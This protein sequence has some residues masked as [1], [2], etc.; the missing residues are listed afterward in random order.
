[1]LKHISYP[2]VKLIFP[3][4]AALILSSAATAQVVDPTST[5]PASKAPLSLVLGNARSLKVNQAYGMA[6]DSVP[7]VVP[8]GRHAVEPHLQLAYSSGKGNGLLG[9]GWDLT[10]GYV[11]NDSRYGLPSPS[12]TDTYNFSIAGD[13]GEM[14]NDGTGNYHSTTELVYRTFQ[15]GPANASGVNTTWTM[16]D[17]QGNLYTFG[18]VSPANLN[19]GTLWLLDSVQDPMGNTITYTYLADE[20]AFYPQTITYTGYGTN[21]GAN[22]VVFTYQA[23][24]DVHT[25]WAHG[26]SQIQRLRL[27]RVEADV[28]QPAKQMAR[29]YV[30]TYSLTEIGESVLSEIQLIGDDNASA[31]TLRKMTYTNH[32]EGWNSIQGATSLNFPLQFNISSGPDGAGD[33]GGVRLVDI[34]GDGCADLINDATILLGDCTGNFNAPPAGEGWQSSYKALPV[35]QI[36]LTSQYG[37]NGEYVETLDNGIQFMDVNG[38]GLADVIIADRT[39]T[40]TLQG[41]QIT[42]TYG[43]YLNTSVPGTNAPMGW[44][45]AANWTMPVSESGYDAQDGLPNCSNPIPSPFFLYSPATD[46]NGNIVNGAPTGVSFVDVNGDGLPDIVWSYFQSSGAGNICIAAVYLNTGSGWVKNVALSHQLALLARSQNLFTINDTWPTGWSFF[47]INGDG[48]GDAVYLGAGS[49]R[50][51]LFTGTSWVQDEN[52][53]SS[54]RSVGLVSVGASGAPTGVLP[55]DFSHDGLTD[56][57]FSNQ[58]QPPKAYR[59][60]GTGFVEDTFMEG[61]MATAGSFQGPIGNNTYAQTAVMADINGD[62]IMDLIPVNSSGTGTTAYLGG[63]CTLDECSTLNAQGKPNGMMLS[64]GMISTWEGPLGE[65]AQIS[66]SR[67]PGTLPLPQYVVSTLT[68]SD[69]RHDQAPAVQESYSYAYEGGSYSNRQFL[70]FFETTEYQPNGNQVITNWN[71]NALFIGQPSA[72]QILSSSGYAIYEKNNTWTAVTPTRGYLTGIQETFSDPGTGGG[73]PVS[74]SAV[75]TM[76]YDGYMNL[77]QFYSNPN[78]SVGGL[79]STTVYTWATNLAAGFWSLPASLTVYAGSGTSGAMMSNSSFFYDSQAQGSISQG[80][81]TSQQD[82][83][84]ASPAQYVIKS[85][86]YD[87]YG[88]VLS[89][90]DRGG[91]AS[92]FAYDS[93]TSTHRLSAVDP[94]GNSIH[95]TFDP[96]FGSVLTDTDAGGNVTSYTYDAFGRIAKV[97]RPGDTSLPGGTT[98]YLYALPAPSFPTGSSVTRRDATSN[99]AAMVTTDLYDAYGQVYETIRTNNAQRIVATTAYDN[100][101]FP[102]RVSKP[103][104]ENAAPVYSALTYDAWHRVTQIVDPAS[105]ITTLSYAGLQVTQTDP[106]GNVTVTTTDPS[107]RIVAK[108]LPTAAGTAI[109]NYVYNVLGDLTQ[110][111]RANGSTSTIAYDMLGRK[112]S[113]TDPNGNFSYQYDSQ[114]HLTGVTGPDGNTIQYT[115]DTTG[116]LLSRIYPNGTTHTITYGTTGNSIGRMVAVTDAAGTVKFAYDARGRTIQRTRYVS[117]NQKTYVTGYAYDS[118]DHVTTTTYPDGFMVNFAYDGLGRVS[119]VIDGAGKA[120]A[121]GFSY[122]ASNRLASLQYGNGMVSNFSYDAL[123]RMAAQT[124]G[125]SGQARIQNLAYAYDRDSNVTSIADIVYSQNEQFTYDPMNRL[126]SATG[127]G[128]GSQAYTYDAVGN[129]LSKG[130]ET[131]IMDPTYP[132]RAD[133]MIV[134]APGVTTCVP[135]SAVGIA[136]DARGNVATFGAA[137]YTYDPENRLLTESNGGSQVESNI[138]DFWGDRVVQQTST[139]TRIFI[140]GI[141]EEGATSASRHVIVGNLLLATIVTPLG[142]QILTVHEVR[143]SIVIP[144][145]SIGPGHPAGGDDK[146]FLEASLGLSLLVMLLGSC[147]RVTG[148]GRRLRVRLGAPVLFQP[149]RTFLNVLLVFSML[150]CGTLDGRAQAPPVRP[151]PA[152]TNRIV[153]SVP[154]VITRVPRIVNKATPNPGTRYYYHLNHL[155]GINLITND[156]GA[157]VVQRQYMPYGEMYTNNGSN[158]N[159]TAPFSFDGG[160]LDGSGTLYYFGA[161]FYSPVL[162]RFLSAD[163]EIQRPTNP[164]EL[165]RYAFAIGNPVRY[166]DP[167]G[168]SIWEYVIAGLCIGGILVIAALSGG[169]GLALFAV[170]ASCIGFGVGA[171]VALALGYSPG[172][173]DFF[174]IALTGAI[175]GASIGAGVGAIADGGFAASAADEGASSEDSGLFGRLFKVNPTVRSVATDMAKSIAF[176][177]PQSVVVHEL[178]GGG[179]DGLLLATCEGTGESAVSGAVIGRLTSAAGPYASAAWRAISGGGGTTAATTIFGAKLGVTL[180]IQGGLW[181]FVGMEHQTLPHFVISQ[182]P[183]VGPWVDSFGNS[184]HSDGPSQTPQPNYTPDLNEPASPPNTAGQSSQPW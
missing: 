81:L 133:C 90:L 5:P 160:R 142:V 66:Y 150:L 77:L 30:M 153:P 184:Q 154:R 96:R 139:E 161:R 38:D 106:L 76:S 23:R 119:S 45:K 159:A 114:D 141:Y 57:I 163:T 47:D 42:P 1:M 14:A 129:L 43:V 12:T 109:T 120:V 149:F 62:G 168:H 171:D 95:S 132:E 33:D 19:P 21:P 70:G 158:L 40:V 79:D 60:T 92:S 34:N 67:A 131:Y 180:V 137:Q 148:S 112:T 75:K 18:L 65:Q 155:G 183:Y 110:V 107:R 86:S 27:T 93:L 88:N 174:Q 113:L 6:T 11:E 82:R 22:Q 63:W 55:Y 177:S 117:A 10:I 157:V 134:T 61:E 89:A 51:L 182:I 72:E 152:M 20:G 166:I 135:G 9:I 115:Y 84:S 98:S 13:G 146:P 3:A 170:V 121:T 85:M 80:L 124:T 111:T 64:D 94:V 103:Y 7:I 165:N 128:Y 39:V 138:Y 118:S 91:N 53:T 172:S 181:T 126:I 130:T 116:N 49:Q 136:Y 29:A 178:Q 68:R 17:G 15:K 175:L 143:E 156:S 169:A 48:M 59:N 147:F 173:A 26:F 176:G 35:D 2:A 41:I 54:L 162:G 167:T 123:D 73:Q 24:P 104:L 140:D 125:L 25:T 16:H 100:M 74:Y 151:S 144:L 46:P 127:A 58:G 83:S 37:L 8:P 31:I 102:Y 108:T 36:V 56:L 78:T 4:L 50:A 145:R 97:V 52:Y 164:M 28:L 71:Q 32:A 69:A 99:G 87:Q 122:T 105:N 179:T 101:G 44:A